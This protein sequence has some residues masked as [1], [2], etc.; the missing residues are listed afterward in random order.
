MKLES[1]YITGTEAALVLGNPFADIVVGNL[2][3]F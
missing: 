1:P 3:N 2:G